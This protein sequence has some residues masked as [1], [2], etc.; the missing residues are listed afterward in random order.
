[1]A[2]TAYLVLAHND[3]IHLERLVK[4]IDYK[5][6]IFIH[7]DKKT[8][9]DRYLHI[10][11]I[12]SVDF[13]A[14]REKV[15]WGGFSQV[16]AI[17]N[18]IKAALKKTALENFTHLVFLTGSDYPIKPVS[19]FYDFLKSNRNRQ[20]I[21]F[22]NLK[23]E[24]PWRLTNYWFMDPFQP[25]LD[26]SLFRRL[27][28]KLFHLGVTRKPLSNVSPAWGSGNWAMTPECAAFIIQYLE[29]NP[30]YLNFY[31]YAHC[32]DEH[33]FHTIVANSPFLQEAGGFREEIRWPHEV[34]NI[35]LNFEGR[36]F[37]DED[38]EFLEDLSFNRKPSEQR[39]SRELGLLMGSSVFRGTF[40]YDSFFLARKFTTE[41]S[42]GLLD[43]IDKNF[44]S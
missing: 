8:K 25:F 19:A 43:K 2:K 35:T 31:K 26:D 5:A 22:I 36:I 10:A 21:K 9:I 24:T 27:L 6:H 15:Y 32:P 14:E 33:F 28:Q 13:I 39:M 42:S 7:L 41:K 3:P 23:E 16:K 12:N 40:D 30:A 1:M 29:Q 38:Y 11:D 37:T 17:L 44:L 4:A 18:L 20:F 34:S